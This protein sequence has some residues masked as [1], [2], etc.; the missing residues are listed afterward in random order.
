MAVKI[1]NKNSPM[2]VCCVETKTNSYLFQHAQIENH[3]YGLDKQEGHFE[4]YLSLSFNF[5]S[6]NNMTTVVYCLPI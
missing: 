3:L 2:N 6:R 5:D 1:I 4:S